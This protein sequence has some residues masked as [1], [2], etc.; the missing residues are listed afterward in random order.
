[1]FMLEVEDKHFIV[2]SER[3]AHEQCWWLIQCDRVKLMGCECTVLISWVKTPL[4]KKRT[5]NYY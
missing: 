3:S 4:K 2:E 1:M 5:M